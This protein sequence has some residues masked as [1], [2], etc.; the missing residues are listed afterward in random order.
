[1]G[2]DFFDSVT[3]VLLELS[4]QKPDMLVVEMSMPRSP[5][6]RTFQTLKNFNPR[7][8][9]GITNRDVTRMA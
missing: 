9:S 2:V 3:A 5:H 1:M 8:L 7:P 4:S 6:Q